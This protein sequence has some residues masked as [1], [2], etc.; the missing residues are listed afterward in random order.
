MIARVR[1]LTYRYPAAAADAAAG[2][3]LDVARGEIVLVHGPSGGGKTTLLR[4]LAGLVPH[5][6]GG[7]FGGSVVVDGLDTRHHDVAV[8]ARRA[9][10]AFQDAESQVLYRSVLR[11]VSFG[12]ANHGVSRQELEPRARAALAAVAAGALAGRTTDTLSGGELQRVALAGVLAPGPSLLLLDEPS[13]QLDDAGASLLA[14]VLRRLADAGTAIVVAEHRTDRYAGVADRVVGIGDATEAPEWPMRP[15]GTIGPTRLELHGLAGG[16]GGRAVFA[17]VD[18]TVGAGEIV[19]IRGS[20]GAGKSTLL[21]LIAGLDAPAAGVILLEGRDVTGAA[22]EDRYPGIALVP[23]DPGRYL[24]CARVVD[25]VRSGGPAAEDA[26]TALDLD[27][28]RERHPRDLSAGERERVAIAT[29]LAADP[30]VLLL[31]EPT[32]GMDPR[33]RA[34]LAA[35]LGDRAAAGRSIVVATHDRQLI[36][37]CRA[38]SVALGAAA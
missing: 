15:A 16:R 31:D 35:L 32:R 36:A 20:N 12:L 10:I 28:L 26:L 13:A 1:D 25:E 11:D 21:R 3:S 4:A 37:M 24:L 34:A 22:A 14:A 30:A 18:L 6:H 7:R 9:G 23:Q 5:F 27:R 38:R 2:L 29:A 33:R 8:I 17:G 19:A